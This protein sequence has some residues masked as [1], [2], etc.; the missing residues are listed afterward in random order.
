MAWSSFFCGVNYTYLKV[1]LCCFS[2]YI[3]Y[4]RWQ[5]QING[6][7]MVSWYFYATTIFEKADS[8]SEVKICVH[9]QQAYRVLKLGRVAKQH[10]VISIFVYRKLVNKIIPAHYN[11]IHNR[12]LFCKTWGGIKS[13]QVL[14]WSVFCV[15]LFSAWLKISNSVKLFFILFLGS[16]ST[17]AFIIIS[18]IVLVGLD[19]VTF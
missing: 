2:R 16:F 5:W 17:A 3:S 8:F 18:I 4:Y 12:L 13:Q 14:A 9:S 19:P 10:C 7:W 15:F 1:F 6:K 11:F